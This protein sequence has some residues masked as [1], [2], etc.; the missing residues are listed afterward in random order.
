MERKQNTEQLL[1]KW[2]SSILWADETVEETVYDHA[3]ND[4]AYQHDPKELI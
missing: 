2:M 4:D 1:T 3:I